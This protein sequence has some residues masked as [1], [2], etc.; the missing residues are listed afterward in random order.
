MN[1]PREEHSP[2][3]SPINM[4][5]TRPQSKTMSTPPV[6]PV[7]EEP[8]SP[9]S[10]S[11]QETPWSIPSLNSTP[12]LGNPLSPGWTHAITI[13]IGHPLKS[14]VGQ[15]LQKGVLYHLIHD[16][17]DLWLSSDP[18]D[19]D[20]IRLLQKYAESDGS[21]GYLPSTLVKN[22]ICLWDFM[23]LLI[24]QDRPDDE[25][26]NKLYYLMDEQWTKLIAY[27][28][29][30]ALIDE[31]Q[32]KQNAHMSAATTCHMPHFRSA[33][34]PVAIRSP[35][36]L[37]LAPFKKS[38]KREASAYSTLK[39]ERYFDKFQRDFFIIAKSNDVSEILDPTYTPGPSP[40][41]QGKFEAKQIF[42][43]NVFN[44]NL[45]TDMGRTKVRKYL[46][47]TDAQAVWKEYSEYLTTSSKGASEKEVNPLSYQNSA[48]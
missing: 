23:N 25:K 5:T 13:I 28:M 39:D 31:K 10:T 45:M 9:K 6:S 32:E 36:Y 44:E 14:E 40:E 1:Q 46:K 7:L 11:S 29:R 34:S 26:Y 21:I 18:S 43:Y 33:K 2:P 4:P 16:A 27:D 35:I 12:P 22:L 17:T 38:I 19:P 3:I 37:E 15:M 48:R 8:E 47:T 30:S 41:E 24:K 20:D 42:M